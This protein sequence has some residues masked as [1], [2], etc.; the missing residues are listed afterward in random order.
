[1][2]R[3]SR[4]IGLRAVVVHATYQSCGRPEPCGD[5]I[6]CLGI[7]NLALYTVLR[8]LPTPSHNT[9]TKV[10]L[11]VKP[12]VIGQRTKETSRTRLRKPDRN[13]KLTQ[14]LTTEARRF[15]WCFLDQLGLR[16]RERVGREL[17]AMRASTGHGARLAFGAGMRPYQPVRAKITAHRAGRSRRARVT[18]ASFRMGKVGEYTRAV[19]FWYTGVSTGPQEQASSGVVRRSWAKRKFHTVRPVEQRENLRR[20]TPCRYSKLS[21]EAS[22]K[23]CAEQC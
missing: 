18:W 19:Q 22:G 20:G 17:S 23:V 7:C 16:H 8:L 21:V 14:Q 5:P 9:R 12:H 13:W 3:H 1:L 15:L 2:R 4:N 11:P 10:R 6:T